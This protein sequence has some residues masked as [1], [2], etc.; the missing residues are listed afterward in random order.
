[1]LIVGSVHLQETELVAAG[2]PCV[3]VSRAGL[4]RGIDGQVSHPLPNR[5]QLLPRPAAICIDHPHLPA[6]CWRNRRR[7]WR[8]RSGL[9]RH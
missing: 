6:W 9:A 4:R 2:F 3:D 5:P 7:S 8:G 1:M